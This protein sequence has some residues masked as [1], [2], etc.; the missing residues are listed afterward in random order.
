MSVEVSDKNER[1]RLDNK[2]EAMEAVS[3]HNLSP[4]CFPMS[5]RDILPPV[6]LNELLHIE[7]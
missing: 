7:H 2:A 5:L 4:C 6:L 3:S 1:W